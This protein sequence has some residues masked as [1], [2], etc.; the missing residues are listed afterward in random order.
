MPKHLF[1][2]LDNTLTPSKSLILEAHVPILKYM[3]E[4]VDVV[5]V[6]GHGEY[7]IRRHLRLELD[8]LYYILGQNGNRAITKDG[9]ILWN[10]SLSPDQKTAIELFIEWSRDDLRQSGMVAE[11][12]D[13]DDIVE[14]RDSQIAFSLIGHHEDKPKKDAFDPDFKKRR[15][16][17]TDA[18]ANGEM[19]KLTDA[20]VE[21]RIGGTTNI[22]FFQLG[23]NKGHNVSEFLKS[24]RWRDEA[25]LYIGDALFPGGNDETVVGVIPTHAVKDYN[26]TYVFLRELKNKANMV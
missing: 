15:Q 23:C 19:K 17:L 2:D 8:G 5:V 9:G 7:D 16:I 25:C 12:R 21:A 14:D 24:M 4:H 11:V 26:E 18:V 13:E 6:S 1:F 22:D 20:G 3:C 10:R